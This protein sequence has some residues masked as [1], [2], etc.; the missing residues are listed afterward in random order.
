MCGAKMYVCKNCL[1]DC[2]FPLY[3]IFSSSVGSSSLESSAVRGTYLGAIASYY[4]LQCRTV[5]LFMRRLRSQPLAVDRLERV[6]HHFPINTNITTITTIT[7]H[8]YLTK[9]YYYFAWTEIYIIHVMYRC[10]GSYNS[11][12]TQQSS[13][14]SLCATTKRSWTTSWPPKYWSPRK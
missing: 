1:I 2:W 3:T 14:S 9:Y 13:T 7:W 12:V 10:M 5:A 6:R 8:R 11:W 4:Y